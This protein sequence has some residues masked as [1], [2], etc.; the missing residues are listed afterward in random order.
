VPYLNTISC[1]H[2]ITERNYAIGD[3][4]TLEVVLYN[5]YGQDKEVEVILEK[6][7]VPEVKT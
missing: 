2:I 3:T 4:A 6:N 1:Q 5:D 7:G